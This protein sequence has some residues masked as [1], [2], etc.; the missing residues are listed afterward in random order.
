MK[1]VRIK[2]K[3][4]PFLIVIIILIL[5]FLIFSA[6]YQLQLYNLKQQQKQLIAQINEEKGKQLIYQ[7]ELARVGTDEY[8]EYLARKYLGYIY[9]DETVMIVIDDTTEN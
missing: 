2:K 9:P 5:Y 3:S 1:R 6:K 7:E 4:T 8:Y